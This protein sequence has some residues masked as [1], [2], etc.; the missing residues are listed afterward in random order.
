MYLDGVGI[1]HRI[2]GSPAAVDGVCQALEVG[3]GTHTLMIR[4]EDSYWGDNTGVRQSSIYL[5]P[6]PEPGTSSL[7]VLG[8]LAFASRR[9]R[10]RGRNASFTYN[11]PHPMS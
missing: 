10:L 8:G 2:V 6:L 1:M 11:F 5:M 3:P 9:A 7:L 4:H